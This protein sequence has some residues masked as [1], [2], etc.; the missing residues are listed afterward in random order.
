M[1][2]LVPRLVLVPRPVFS[3]SAVAL[4]LAK[5]PAILLGENTKQGGR[6]GWVFLP[7]DVLL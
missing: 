6:Q 7:A 1:S 3:P 5:S 2:I 4:G